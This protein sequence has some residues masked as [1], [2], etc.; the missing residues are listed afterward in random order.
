M[1]KNETY[2]RSRRKFIKNSLAA[3][4]MVPWLGSDLST[5]IPMRDDKLKVYIF[6]KHLQFLDYKA[7]AD[8]AAEMGF[9]GV[10]VTVRPKGHVEPERVADDLPKAAEALKRAG[11]PPFIMTTAVDDA[12]D[13]VDK[14]LLQ[15]ASAEGFQ[16]YR[17]NWLPFPENVSMPQAMQQ[18]ETTVKKIGE[19]NK[20][21]NLVGCYQNHAG[22][23][24][25]ASLWELWQ[26]M[27]QAD[28]K[29]MGVQYDIRHAMVEGA[30]SWENG[31]RLIHDRIRLLTI[32]DFKWQ[33]ENNHSSVHDVPMGQGMID[34]KKYFS[35]LKKYKV[36]VPVT[37]HI[38]YELGGVEHGANKI[39][40]DKK[41]VFKAMKKDLQLVRQLWQ[42]AP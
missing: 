38:E 42:E 7:M 18:Y 26:L 41:E 32:K 37:L 36:N 33:T 12:E 6:S 2:D 25:G 8:A 20:Q 23:L 11:L 19:L 27:K 10:D 14:K 39:T 17:M 13:P 28:K 15:T 3:G 1:I 22:E 35:L 31:L 4:A 21:L 40:I 5:L 30:Q 34:F 29:H 9:D 16:F 24:V